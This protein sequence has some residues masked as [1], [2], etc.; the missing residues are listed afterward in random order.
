MNGTYLITGVPFL[1][2]FPPD[3][4]HLVESFS[5]KSFEIVLPTCEYQLSASYWACLWNPPNYRT[6]WGIHADVTDYICAS[7]HAALSKGK[8]IQAAKDL[9]KQVKWFIAPVNPQKEWS[10]AFMK[11]LWKTSVSEMKIYC[12]FVIKLLL[13]INIMRWRNPKAAIDWEPWFT[14]TIKLRFSNS[15]DQS[16]AC[17]VSQLFYKVYSE[18][19]CSS[20]RNWIALCLWGKF[21]NKDSPKNENEEFVLNMTV[22]FSSIFEN[23]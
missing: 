5:Y 3:V 11:Q 7:L 12:I 15:I 13:L 8:V 18:M 1:I 14:G 22:S 16:D 19:I 23:H 20:V 9:V 4:N 21:V 6:K 2:F 10:I 17:I